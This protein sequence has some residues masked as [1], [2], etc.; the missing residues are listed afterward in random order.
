M[1][2]WLTQLVNQT[3]IIPL[4]EKGARLLMKAGLF[5][6][7]AF[8]FFLGIVFLIVAFFIWIYTLAGALIASLAIAGGFFLIALIAVLGL[9]SDRFFQTKARKPAP[10]RPAQGTAHRGP[11]MDAERAEENFRSVEI[12]DAIQPIIETLRSL[13]MKREELAL[14]AGAELA[15]KLPPL[16]LMG[17]LLVCGFL[18]GRMAKMPRDL[19][20]KL[21]LWSAA[22]QPPQDSSV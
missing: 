3:I 17:L 5:C 13:G 4:Q 20:Q 14:L 6:V 15:K 19:W 16:T 1:N 18:I 2:S 8:T 21:E 7:A 11:N 10:A 9:F 12:T 22:S